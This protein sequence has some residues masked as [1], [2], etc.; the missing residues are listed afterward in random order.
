M[1]RFRIS[2]ENNNTRTTPATTTTTHTHHNPHPPPQQA[3]PPSL[4]QHAYARTARGISERAP[5]DADGGE[6]SSGGLRRWNPIL[7]G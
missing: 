6:G 1:P 4:A 7:G 5:A 3:P 2:V